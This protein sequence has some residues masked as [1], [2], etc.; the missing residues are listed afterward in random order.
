M[1]KYI[2]E[3]RNWA[4][5]NNICIRCYKEKAWNGRQMCPE[6]LYKAQECSEKTRSESSKEQRR[7]Y[8]KR[9][10]ELCIAFGVCRE[11]LKRKATV[12]LKCLECHIK[13]VKRNENRRTKVPRNIRI[14]LKLC[15]FCGKPAI[16][17]NKVCEKHYEVYSKNILKSKHDT[18]N[19]VWRKIQS[20]EIKYL[21]YKAG[22]Y[23]HGKA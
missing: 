6:C 4:I 10:R 21:K 2:E 20:S 15:Y 18:S 19:H 12:G 17:G 11:C 1:N 5:K 13:E 8:I 16:E 7:K 9:K 23:K 14:E 22:G 3:Y